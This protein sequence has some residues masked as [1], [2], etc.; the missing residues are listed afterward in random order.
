MLGL[1]PR[2]SGLNSDGK[3]PDYSFATSSPSCP[4]L[5]RAPTPWC[6]AAR[7]K[8]TLIVLEQQRSVT[9]WIPATSA[10]MT[11]RWRIR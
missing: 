11:E 10:G 2:L 5:L 8:G 3:R 9:A 4:H 6:A 1:V 7:Q